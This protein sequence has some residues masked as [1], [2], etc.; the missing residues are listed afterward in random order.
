MVL[1]LENVGSNLLYLPK[2]FLVRQLRPLL[3]LICDSES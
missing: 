1:G 3:T 2:H